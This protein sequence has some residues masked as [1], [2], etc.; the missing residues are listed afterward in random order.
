MAQPAPGLVPGQEQNQAETEARRAAQGGQG[1]SQPAQQQNAAPPARGHDQGHQVQQH[2]IVTDQIGK[3]RMPFLGPPGNDARR[4]QQEHPLPAQGIAQALQV[5]LIRAALAPE[6][7]RRLEAGS[8]G[9]PPQDHP[10][11]QHVAHGPAGRSQGHQERKKQG[12][13]VGIIIAQQGA[14]QKTGSQRGDQPGG[15]ARL[16]AAQGP[17]PG[18]DDHRHQACQHRR[19]PEGHGG[20]IGMQGLGHEPQH[21]GHGMPHAQT[22][23]LGGGHP[24]VGVVGCQQPFAAQAVFR[25]LPAGPL[26]HAQ[27]ESQSQG[28]QAPEQA[29]QPVVR[30]VL[31]RA[32]RAYPRHGP[33]S[34]ARSVRSANTGSTAFPVPPEMSPDGLSAQN[35]RP[36]PA[37]A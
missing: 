37:A 35:Q 23:T 27:A 24:M 28:Q 25:I 16:H 1:V 32:G 5:R 3:N 14:G 8:Q 2:H 33:S 15:H 30:R 34:P 26:H 12:H 18:E 13:Q 6:A 31:P 4:A 11:Q 22:E 21:L 17:D 36:L 7:L 29:P 10:R 19:E 20:R 9:Q